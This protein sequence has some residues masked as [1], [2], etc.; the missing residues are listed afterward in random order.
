MKNCFFTFVYTSASLLQTN[1]IVKD[2]AFDMYEVNI[3]K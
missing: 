3:F 1:Y 2:D